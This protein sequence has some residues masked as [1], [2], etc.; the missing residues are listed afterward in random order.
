MSAERLAPA[1]SQP[2]ETLRHTL[3]E[4]VFG[5]LSGTFVVSLGVYLLTTAHAVTG[6]TAG[7]ALERWCPSGWFRASPSCTR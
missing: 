7:L 2:A 4:D 5:L 6:G 3:L 1:D